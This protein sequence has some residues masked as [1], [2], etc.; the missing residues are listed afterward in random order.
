MARLTLPRRGWPLPIGNEQH[1]RWLESIVKSVLVMNLLDAVL[2][3]W[4]VGNGFAT[5]AN[6]FL[7]D[8]VE[9]PLAF[10]LAKLTVVS[11]GSIFLWR[12]RQHPLAVVAI[13]FAFL[14]YYLVLLTHVRLSG[15]VLAELIFQAGLR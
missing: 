13:F 14:I 2:T 6:A 7:A 15:L 3:L 5:E 11:L 8:L 1:Y 4:W 12:L 10:V 9:R